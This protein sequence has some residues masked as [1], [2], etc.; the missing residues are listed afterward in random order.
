VAARGVPGWPISRLRETP[1][2]GRLAT[3]YVF[4]PLALC[5]AVLARRAFAFGSP[6]RGRISF[7]PVTGGEVGLAVVISQTS[8]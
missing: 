2:D 7:E 1:L 5:V 8:W 3:R 4:K 6:A